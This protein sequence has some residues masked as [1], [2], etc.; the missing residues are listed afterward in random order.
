MFVTKDSL[1]SGNITASTPTPATNM[2]FTCLINGRLDP[3]LS[4]YSCTMDCGDPEIDA[5][6]MTY[7]FQQSHT[8][9]IGYNV[10]WVNCSFSSS[11][12]PGEIF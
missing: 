12:P 7:T 8:T 10:K 2:T 9:M 4:D 5:S 6:V 1:K 11:I 3:K